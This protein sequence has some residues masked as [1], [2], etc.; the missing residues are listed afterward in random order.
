MTLIFDD[1]TQVESFVLLLKQLSKDYRITDGK[2]LSVSADRLLAKVF[3]IWIRS[4]YEEKFLYTICRKNFALSGERL[5]LDKISKACSLLAAKSKKLE[6]VLFNEIL[7]LLEENK[8][9]SVSGV[10]HFRLSKYRKSLIDIVEK[11]IEQLAFEREKTNFIELLQYFVSLQDPVYR[12]V[13]IVY[14]CDDNQFKIVDECY[15]TINCCLNNDL[16]Q[17]FNRSEITQEDQMLSSLISIAPERIVIHDTEKKMSE[18][19]SETLKLV[20]GW[21]LVFCGGCGLCKK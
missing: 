8:Q 6:N 7:Q 19:F 20:F 11:G 12:M 17:T 4:Q 5:E 3:T 16:T 1:V 15:D 21:R 14:N 13:H 9:L 2:I 10:V 18:T